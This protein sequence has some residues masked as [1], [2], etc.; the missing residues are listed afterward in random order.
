ME[1]A[2]GYPKKYVH[3]HLTAR[4]NP[5]RSTANHP[6]FNNSTLLGMLPHVQTGH[7]INQA[8]DLRQNELGALPTGRE[9]GTPEFDRAKI[10]MANRT[11]STHF[12][13]SL[14]VL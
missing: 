4:H 10:R 8:M 5:G 3:G 1:R 6:F 14:T 12:P 13:L 9:P 11:S 2:C 7:H